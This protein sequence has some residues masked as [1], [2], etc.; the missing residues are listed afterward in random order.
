MAQIAKDLLG[1]R[2]AWHHARA[3]PAVHARLLD[4]LHDSSN[5]RVFAIAQ[6]VDIDLRSILE[7]PVDQDRAVGTRLHRRADIAPQILRRVNNLHGTPSEHE[8]RPDQH[9]V[10]DFF[11]HGQ[12]FVL[13]SRRSSLRSAQLEP[14]EH[15]GKMFAIFRHLDALGRCADD[16][17]SI[18]FQSGSQIQRCLPS[19]LNDGRIALLALVNIKDILKRQWFEIQFVARVVIG[20]DGLRV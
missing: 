20:R 8:G 2:K 5:R 16:I 19:E 18:G 3:V 12:S 17:D 4:V 13:V 10:A 6:A 7:K 15:R 1:K 14:L 9:R 11:R